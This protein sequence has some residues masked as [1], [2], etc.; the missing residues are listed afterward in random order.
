[1][2]TTARLFR[3]ICMKRKKN[4]QREVQELIASYCEQVSVCLERFQATFEEARVKFDR[5]AVQKRYESV[6]LA[7][8]QADDI[9]RELENLMYSR[10]V[11]PESR[12]DI[13]GLIET[14]DRVPNCAESAVRM[15]IKQHITLP[16]EICGKIVELV[17]VCTKCVMAMIE[18]VSQLFNNFIDAS[19]TVGKIDKLESEADRVE[20]DLVEFV[21]SS[22]F[23]DLQK[24]LLRDLIDKIGGVADRAENVGD[25]IR[26]MV[27]KRS[28]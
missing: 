17:T 19:I 14:M 21:F 28:V 8:G 25:R 13:L 22:D 18:G 23:S 15:I 6:H 16:P 5:E 3:R 27:A 11:F 4:R 12:G 7:E 20:S 10:A 1:M 24:N 26:I 9:R 2:Q